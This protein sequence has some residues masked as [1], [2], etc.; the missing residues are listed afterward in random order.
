MPAEFIVLKNRYYDSVYLMRAAKKVAGQEGVQQAA[1]VM[2]SER[3]L[4]ALAQAGYDGAGSLGATANDLV[5]VVVA[6]DRSRARA[7]LERIEEWLKEERP[8]GADDVRTLEQALATLP[9]ANL[10]VVSVPGEYAAR[11]ARQ[12]LERGLNVFLF[13]DNVSI[14]DEL[15]LKR[16]AEERG[17][18]VMGP[19][20]GTAIVAGV[21]I[22]FANVVRRGPIGVIGASGTGTQEVAT[23]AHRAGSG[24]S[25]AIGTGSRDLSDAIG[26]ITALRAL[27]ALEADPGT[28]V[29]ALISKPPGRA[30][31]AKVLE[32]LARGHKP[33]VTCFLGVTEDGPP[34][35]NVTTTHDLE[36]AAMAAV[37]K[38]SP[39]VPPH[40]EGGEGRPRTTT[41]LDALI[42]RE[43]ASKAPTQRF[44]RGVF[45]GG[46]FCY[47]AQQVLRT[48][49]L[50]VQSNEPLDPAF[51]LAD[52]HRSV[53]HTVVD[54]GVD[55]FIVGRPHPMLDSTRR[56]ERVLAEARDPEVAVLL[57][58]F[59]L[60]YGAS[61]DP[62]G[63][64][65]GAIRHAR[66]TARNRGG[67]LT[68]A[69]SICGTEGDPQGLARQT[70][71]LEEA[72]AIVFP[73]SVRAARFCGALI[74]GR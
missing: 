73:S 52:A 63:E 62:V 56:A 15:S 36:S 2:G 17:L 9:G 42:E 13:S 38:T 34:I 40:L 70:K 1:L 24:V 74:T 68:V 60:G 69:A 16:L 45:A 3:N 65:A 6:S 64:M 46:T 7:V 50:T 31:L 19:D 53:G 49:G 48:A 61:P 30:T 28:K 44:V 14:E 39:P 47:Q 23:L 11:E 25:Q 33:V 8:Q 22:G 37:G 5:A 67:S 10:A 27:D 71:A 66:E 29:I 4:D 54:M 32:R 26:G 20:C 55:P 18:L 41:I 51:R 72:G 35:P 57:L 59:I 58:D 21:G 12:A 43:R